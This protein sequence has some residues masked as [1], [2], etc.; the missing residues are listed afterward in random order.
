MFP[1]EYVL[2]LELASL[3]L[4]R[5]LDGIKLFLFF[6]KNKNNLIPLKKNSKHTLY[7]IPNQCY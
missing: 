2:F 7:Q 1:K 3:A 6:A 5:F 4:N